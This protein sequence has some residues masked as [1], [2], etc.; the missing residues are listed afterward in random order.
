MSTEFL[1]RNLYLYDKEVLSSLRVIAWGKLVI[2]ENLCTSSSIFLRFAHKSKTNGCFFRCSLLILLSLQCFK[3]PTSGKE[4]SKKIVYLV[5]K[6]YLE[7]TFVIL[8]KL[9]NT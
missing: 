9:V 1:N 3:T 5:K 8:A 2:R 6:I 7:S 4:V